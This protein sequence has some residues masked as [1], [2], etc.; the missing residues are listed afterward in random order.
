MSLYASGIIRIISDPVLKSFDSGT[1]VANFAGGIQEGKDK[2]GN[3]INNV[4]DVEIWGKS[5]EVVV[6]RCKKGD[7]IMVTGNVKRQDWEDKK[8][9]DKRSKHVLAV[10]RFEF[11]PRA[12]NNTSELD[13]F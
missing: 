7:S 4:I 11:L 3:W 2:N 10:S 12:A 13:A 8:T 9:G 1:Q 5:A 6:D